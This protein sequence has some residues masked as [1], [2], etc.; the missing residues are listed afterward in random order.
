MNYLYEDIKPTRL[1]IKQCPH[2]GLKYFGKS[3]SQNIESYPGSGIRWNNHLEKHGVEPSHL[4]NSDWY[5]DTSIQRFA[6][7]FSR[8]NMIVSSK[9]WANLKEE[10]G[11]DGGFNHLNDVSENHI[12]RTKR[13]RVSADI[14]IK[15]IY[16]VDNFSQTEKFRNENSLRV[17]Q[18][19]KD[20]IF[21]HVNHA[22]FLGKSHTEEAKKSIGMKNSIH[23][24]GLGNSHYGKMWIYSDDLRKSKRIYKTDPIPNGWVK[25]RKMKFD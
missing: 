11:L 12:E 6:L 20:G 17:K 21:D 1:Y 15:E 2:C 18:M 10:N 9:Q 3:N 24:S 8:M 13:G 23:Q 14:R 4:W 7:R 16:G 19:W 22:T 25:G 5:Y